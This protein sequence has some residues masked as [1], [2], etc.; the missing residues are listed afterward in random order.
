V[1]LAAWI[2]QP[3]HH[4]QRQNFSKLAA[5]INLVTFLRIGNHA[6]YDALSD[7]SPQNALRFQS[8]L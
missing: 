5:T 4:Q 1:Q 6:E 7:Y 2:D 8:P 3:I